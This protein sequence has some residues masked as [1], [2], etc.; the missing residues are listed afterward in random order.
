MTSQFARW[1]GYIGP[2]NMAE[3]VRLVSQDQVLTKHMGNVFSDQEWKR[4]R[5][6][7]DIG[8]GPGGWALDVARKYAHLRVVGVD[9][10]SHMLDYA[11]LL[12]KAEGVQNV[13]FI[14]A[15]ATKPLPFADGSFDYVNLRL[16]F[17]FLPAPT[18]PS[19]LLECHRL[20]R[21]NGAIGL[22]DH[23]T[24]VS[25]SAALDKLSGYLV[26]AMYTTGRGFSAT[27]RWYGVTLMAPLLLED[28][29]F[30]RIQERAF[31]MRIRPDDKEGFASWKENILLQ[32]R[33]FL[34]FV[35]KAGVITEEENNVLRDQLIVDMQSPRFSALI[36]CS[37][38]WGWKPA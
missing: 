27:G 22:T 35:Q 9:S 26:T 13:E 17:S 21:P 4:I 34:P 20:L 32:T 16:V 28:A 1:E 36:Y 31:S 24:A 8:C 37:T 29:G 6:V 30:T 7:L 11:R 3:V 25:T 14:Q 33:T 38:A 10:S 5:L 19:F 2:D 23:E 18:W 12:A 15:D